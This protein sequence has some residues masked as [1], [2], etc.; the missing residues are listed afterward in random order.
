MAERAEAPKGPAAPPQG[1]PAP[2]AGRRKIL[3]VDDSETVLLVE[4]S[5]LSRSYLVVTAKNGEEGV[6]KAIAERPDLILMDVMMPR[7]NGFDAVRR[8]RSEPA[9]RN[10]PVIMVT[11]RS[12]AQNVQTGYESGCTDYVTKPFDGPG[13]LAKVKSRLPPP[14]DA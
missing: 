1:D 3:A 12:E 14:R 10:I 7:M 5:L 8:L 6:A 4:R 11:T 13:L 2:A 9:T